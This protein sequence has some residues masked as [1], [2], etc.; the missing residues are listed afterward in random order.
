MTLSR[1][2]TLPGADSLVPRLGAVTDTT[3]GL[4]LVVAAAGSRTVR[5]TRPVWSPFVTLADRVGD[6][7]RQHTPV[8]RAVGALAEQGARLRGR[9]VSDAGD[10]LDRL[11]PT[12]VVEVLRRLDLTR[13]VIDNVDLDRVVAAVDLDSAVGRV[14]IEQ[15][16]DRVDVEAVAARVDVDAVAARLDM[17]GVLD[18]MDLTELALR[19]L[20][21]DVLVAAVLD[22]VD[23]EAIA[24]EVIESVDLPDIIRESSGALT[25]DTVRSARIRGAAADQALGRMRDRLRS[26]HNGAGVPA[27]DRSVG[28]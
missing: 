27:S 9:V 17:D 12:V 1:H 25:S 8:S 19:R 16:L 23:L 3:L 18:R 15:I 26:R 28:P 4:A 20:D 24:L 11:L 5:R 22:H 2:E 21:W 10:L 13:I 14:D 7:A 6:T